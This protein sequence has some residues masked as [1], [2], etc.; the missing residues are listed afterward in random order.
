[1]PT[2]PLAAS[3][4]QPLPPQRRRVVVAD[5]DPAVRQALIELLQ[6][7]ERLEVV[8]GAGDGVEA[9]ASCL[10]HRPDV[11]VVDVNM[12]NGGGEHAARELSRQLPDLVIIAFSANA[13][14]TTRRTMAEAGAAAFV[15]KGAMD[16]LVDLVVG[17]AP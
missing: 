16:R 13:D 7:D 15:A 2:A 17:E 1:M 14:R 4:G 5:D 6:A 12:P 11:L 10:Q 3:A 9:V 8:A